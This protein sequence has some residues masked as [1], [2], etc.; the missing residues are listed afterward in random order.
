MWL[1]VLFAA[2]F[3]LF[4]ASS[5]ATAADN[6]TPADVTAAAKINVDSEVAKLQKQL[7][8]IKQQVSN[9]ASDSKYGEL[10]DAVQQLI[11]NTNDLATALAPLQA[12]LQAQVDV[13]GPAPEQG[14]AITETSEVTRK[15]ASL[16]VQKTKLDAQLEQIQAIRTGGPQS[17]GADS[18]AASQCA[19]NATG[20]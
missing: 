3:A 13:L 11:G 8:G 5:P 7:D 2:L 10:N 9:A 20:T 1:P 18:Y 19:K 4:C 12:Q 15:R 6:T 14:A 16:S 17:L